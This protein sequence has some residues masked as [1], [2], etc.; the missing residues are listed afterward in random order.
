MIKP[1]AIQQGDELIQLGQVFGTPLVVKGWTW[2]PL[3]Q[4]IVWLVMSWLAGKRSLQRTLGQ[5]LESGGVSMG[6]ILGSE[7]AHNLAHAAAAQSTGKNMDALRVA[8]GMPLVIYYQVDDPQVTPDEHIRRALGGPVINALLLALG[9]FLRAGTAPGSG[10]REAANTAVLA[11]AFLVGAGMLPM[12]FLDGGV[13]L[14]W[15]L[16]KRGRLPAQ[17][18]ATV[19]S[20]NGA[21]GVALGAAGMLALKKRRWFLGGLLG[22]LAGLSIAVATSLIRE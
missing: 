3:T 7:W 20:A 21:T 5:R 16:V 15:G 6:I 9:L 12:P 8:W 2:L 14:K 4:M 17:A 11:N 10:G 18:D 22:L 13:I 1:T 19:R